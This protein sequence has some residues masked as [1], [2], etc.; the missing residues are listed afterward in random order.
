MADSSDTPVKGDVTRVLQ[1]MREGDKRA[2]EE[3][4]PLVYEHLRS[5]AA[6]QFRGRSDQTLQPTALVHEA[7]LRLAG[8]EAPSWES[9]G[10]FMAVAATAMRQILID[11]ARKSGAVKRGGD[12]A[13]VS[14][15]DADP[16]VAARDVD[17]IALHD[18]LERLA[19]LDERQA[20][21]VE[22][23][24]FGGLSNQE[25]GEVLGASLRT[26]EREWRA[27]KAWLA[28]ELADFAP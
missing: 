28:K 14:L 3:I 27:V 5:L 4:V 2:H 10:H 19:K 9:R 21:L 1:R 17:V 26:V 20:R 13:R 18:A 11:H 12:R 25:I 6:S 7:F 22:L 23:R 15:S 16:G 24:V 8:Q